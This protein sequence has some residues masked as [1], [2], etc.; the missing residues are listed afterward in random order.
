[1]VHP[2]GGFFD[3]PLFALATI[4]AL[5][6]PLLCLVALP[7]LVLVTFCVLI[8]SPFICLTGA[9][10]HLKLAL[11]CFITAPLTLL[12]LGAFAAAVIHPVQVLFDLPDLPADLLRLI[13]PALLGCLLVRLA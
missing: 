12:P 7:P 3:L 5:I 9:L 8:R 13:S 10:T 4:A 1:V 11:G 6:V 2:T